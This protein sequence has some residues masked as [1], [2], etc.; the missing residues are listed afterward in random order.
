MLWES[1]DEDGPD[2]SD[3]IR[4]LLHIQQ[5]ANRA[6]S[7]VETWA[8]THTIMSWTG[9]DLLH[10][11]FRV[12]EIGAFPRMDTSVQAFGREMT[13]LIR[14]APDLG[15]NKKASGRGAVYRGGP[16]KGTNPG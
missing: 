4:P 10:Q 16:D 11:S 15:W 3:D 9:S 6:I 14:E 5:E 8:R 12:W 2:P 1:V 7:S 13:R